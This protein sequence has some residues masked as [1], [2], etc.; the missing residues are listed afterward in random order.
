M[1][2][3]ALSGLALGLAAGSAWADGGYLD[4]G[5][6]HAHVDLDGIKGHLDATTVSGAPRSTCRARCNGNSPVRRRIFRA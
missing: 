1:K 4:V 6:S 3:V 2:I 5:R